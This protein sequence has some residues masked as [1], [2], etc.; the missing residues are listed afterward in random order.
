VCGLPW[1]HL[2]RDY[3]QLNYCNFLVNYDTMS[4]TY[5]AKH[6]AENA[7]VSH[8]LSFGHYTLILQKSFILVL[9]AK[10]SYTDNICC[11]IPE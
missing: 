7:F 4:N 10:I 1:R 6:C 11:P 8:L 2:A 9:K 5:D 3:T